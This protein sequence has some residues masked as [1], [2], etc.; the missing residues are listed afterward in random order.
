LTQKVE[1]SENWAFFMKR[2]SKIFLF[3]LFFWLIFNLITAA[4]TELLAD[5]AYY[6]LYGSKMAW[7]YFDHPPLI[8]FYNSIIDRNIYHSEL[9]VR[10]LTVISTS[11]Y[12]WIVFKMINPKEVW[13]FASIALS[14]LAI[15]LFG[16]VSVP[17][18][19]LL[20]LSALFYYFYQKYQQEES[21]NNILALIII[22]PLMF[23][24]KYHAL[25]V[26]VFSLLS[27]PSVFKR[28]SFYLIT[29][30]SLVLYFPHIWWQIS[31][32][33]PS[34]KY[35]FVE[36]NASDYEFKFTLDYLFGQLMFYSPVCLL[37]VLT[38]YTKVEKDR[39]NKLFKFNVLGFFLF[40]LVN[41][42]KGYVEVNWTLPILTVIIVWSYQIISRFSSTIKTVFINF[43]L[44][45]IICL[46]ALKVF[47]IKQF[48]PTEYLERL[49]EFGGLSTVALEVKKK[50]GNKPLCAT[51]YQEAALFSYYLQQDVVSINLE[52]R[53]NI[54]NNWNSMAAVCNKDVYLV[55]H[56][57]SDDIDSAYRCHNNNLIVSYVKNIPAYR[58]VEI[59][60]LV[61]GGN[62]VRIILN[63]EWA[64][65]MK[66]QSRVHDNRL[67]YKIQ[68]KKS[69]EDI[70]V[71]NF[72]DLQIAENKA[73]VFNLKKPTKKGNYKLE[74]YLKTVN[75]GDWSQKFI[76]KITID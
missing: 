26:V 42:Y 8:A 16:F 68:D 60:S 1:S 30:L 36:R 10:F 12:L 58:G 40:F 63:K 50:I 28:K 46:V 52:S 11:I 24:T 69:F 51:R 22:T 32:D 76:K 27:D 33:Y 67:L 48:V 57:E 56:T 59:D 25:L 29:L 71:T 55:K 61:V 19:P 35:H 17:D 41:T 4:N 64:K 21:W 3:I 7:G 38:N 18:S 37:V 2:E 6:W 70:E 47:A 20:L 65:Y 31:H 44:L 66:N 23:Y 14:S 9:S 15:N 34:I 54:F 43:N 75:F 62:S 49:R 5:E 39:V 13:L 73:V 45:I 74:L 72:K 53:K